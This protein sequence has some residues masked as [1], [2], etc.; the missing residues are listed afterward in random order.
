MAEPSPQQTDRLKYEPIVRRARWKWSNGARLAV[1]VIPNIEYFPIT[2]P[3]TNLS[4]RA[5]PLKPDIPNHTWREYG[6]RVG[7]WR[8]M[9][10]L[11]KLKVRGTVALNAAVCDRYPD[12]LEAAK[13]LGWEF[14][15]HGWTNSEQLPGLSEDDERRLLA[16]VRDRMEA[17]FGAPPRGW[18]SPA[19]LENWATPDLLKEEGYGYTCNWI[20]DEQPTWLATRA[21]PLM[22]MPYPLEVNDLPAFITRHLSTEDFAR[23]IRA[24]F[25]ELYEDSKATARVMGIALHPMVIGAPHRIGALREGLK[26]MLGKDEVWFATGREIADDFIRQTAGKKP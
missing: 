7:V 25:D 21:G 10:L 6:P 18:L 2:S 3:G 11:D 12:C 14:M 13:D 17:F 4:P 9:E 8:L 15:G 1:W 23:M 5:T 20:H 26:H 22:T 19:L 16:R 24:Q